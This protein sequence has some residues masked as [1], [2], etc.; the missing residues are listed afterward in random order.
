M[1]AAVAYL[2][3]NSEIEIAYTQLAGNGPGIIFCGG[4]MSDL[5]GTKATYLEQFCRKHHLAFLRFD[6]R[7]HGQSTGDMQTANISL[8]KAD[9]LAVLEQLTT[10]PQILI[11]SSMGAWIAILLAQAKPERIKKIMA[12]APA[13]DFTEDLIWASLS[14]EKQARL[15]QNETLNFPSQYPK[16]Y[17]ITREFIEDG[18]RNL[19]LRRP[20]DLQCPV[21][22]LHGMQDTDVP[23]QTSINLA[24]KIQAMDVKITLIKDGD[25]RL[26]REE[27]L[28]CMEQILQTFC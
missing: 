2:K 11:G 10:G 23:W 5:F 16:P 28:R 17:A 7:G 24:E 25:H 8:W 21:H 6:Y 12:I 20:I 13:P 26:A 14:K 1:A 19:I 3:L 27:D 4:F 15:L 9:A 18:R 22:L